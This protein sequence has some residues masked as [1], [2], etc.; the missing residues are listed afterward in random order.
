MSHKEGIYVDATDNKEFSVCDWYGFMFSKEYQ[1]SGK[2][3]SV[4]RIGCEKSKLSQGTIPCIE[5]LHRVF[6]HSTIL[7]KIAVFNLNIY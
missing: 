4:Y 5:G 3:V 6:P 7:E 2:D 1:Q